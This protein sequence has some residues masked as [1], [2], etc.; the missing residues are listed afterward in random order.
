[1][2]CRKM[3][4]P[5]TCGVMI[6]TASRGYLF[7]KTHESIL[8]TPGTDP[9][10]SWN[11]SLELL[12]PI[13]GTPGFHPW[14]PRFSEQTTSFRLQVPTHIWCTPGKVVKKALQATLSHTAS[15]KPV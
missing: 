9:W 12:E 15:R 2:L 6:I 14:L 10:N 5:K 4:A 3:A 7:I 1:T 11:R 13:L 8:G